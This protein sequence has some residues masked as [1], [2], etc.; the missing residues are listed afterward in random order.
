MEAG[1][2]VWRLPMTKPGA[3]CW[4]KAA[5]LLVTS[6]ANRTSPVE[7]GKWVMENLL[8]V[9]PPLRRQMYRH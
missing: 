2:G 9:P 8:G 4:G 1:S 7:R 3:G 6:V 5:I